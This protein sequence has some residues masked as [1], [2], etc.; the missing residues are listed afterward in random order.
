[1][2]NAIMLS[3]NV[4]VTLGYGEIPARGLARYLAV[5]EGMLGWFLLS[6]FSVSLISQV[7]Q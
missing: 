4:F 2:L 3:I 6:I 1:V 7:L 5:I